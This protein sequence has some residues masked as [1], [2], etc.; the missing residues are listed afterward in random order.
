[1][2][3]IIFLSE[4]CKYS[5]EAY[6]LIRKIG[7]DKFKFVNVEE[8]EVLPNEIDRV[9]AILT[10]EKKLLFEQE[11]FEFL[12]K[13]QD[14]DPFMINEMGQMS[15]KYSYMDNTNQ[16]IDHNYK[17]LNREERI[18]TPNEEDNKKIVNYDDYLAQRD[19]DLKV[20]T[21]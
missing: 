11:L 4:K 9:P 16:V 18:M 15:D 14:V 10:A 7:V 21:H 12:Y 6:S 2:S 1:M 8:Q 13:M 5:S 17:F 19:N 3:H 20:F